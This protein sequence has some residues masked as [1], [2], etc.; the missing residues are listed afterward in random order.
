MSIFLQ[1]G[2]KVFLKNQENRFL[3]L[4]RSS[5]RYPDIKNNWDIP[6]GRIIPGTSLVE[7]LQREVSE[8]TSLKVVGIPRFL[9]AQ[10]IIRP[11]KEKHIVRLT[12]VS[13]ATGEVILDEEHT[14]FKWLTADEM[15]HMKNLDEF[16]REILEKKILV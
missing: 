15:L 16:T 5:E 13:D 9:Y 10:D 6:G 14:D 4:E 7:N 8:E 12:F 2:V 11:E 3:L 1:V